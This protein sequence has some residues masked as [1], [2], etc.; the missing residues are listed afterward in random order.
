MDLPSHLGGVMKSDAPHLK[1]FHRS[2]HPVPTENLR[3][4]TELSIIGCQE[5]EMSGPARQSDHNVHGA[6][7]SILPSCLA[8]AVK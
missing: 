8:T 7:S 2:A 5:R 3:Y 1:A 6:H 4:M